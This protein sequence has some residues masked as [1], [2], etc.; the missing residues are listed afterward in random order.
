MRASNE[1]MLGGKF[2]S[3]N[4]YRAK[5]ALKFL[6]SQRWLDKLAEELRVNSNT[7]G[8]PYLKL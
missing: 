5:L 2:F 6:I 3:E 1:L 8:Q 4:S 7:F